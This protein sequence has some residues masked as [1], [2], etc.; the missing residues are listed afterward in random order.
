VHVDREARLPVIGQHL[1]PLGWR[2]ELGRLGG[3]VE[4][5]REL[6]FLTSGAGNA[7]RARDEA[8]LPEQRAARLAE[9]VTGA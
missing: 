7:L 6:T 2:A 8:Q 5:K 4:R 3:R 1:L 9:R